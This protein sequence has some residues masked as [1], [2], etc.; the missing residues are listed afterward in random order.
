VKISS[1]VMVLND[2][3]MT[4]LVKPMALRLSTDLSS[5]EGQASSMTSWGYLERSLVLDW[6]DIL[7]IVDSK[8]TNAIN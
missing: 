5:S 7:I 2:S 4:A 1:S 8:L 6:M 3:S